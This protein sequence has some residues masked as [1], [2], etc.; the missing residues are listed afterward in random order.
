MTLEYKLSVLDK[1]EEQFEGHRE[2]LKKSIIK[3]HNEI[4]GWID[5]M[6]DTKVLCEYYVLKRR[7]VD[8]MRTYYDRKGRGRFKLISEPRAREEEIIFIGTEREIYELTKDLEVKDCFEEELTDRY[9]ELY[10][11]IDGAA[12]VNVIKLGRN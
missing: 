10:D 3:S 12:R 7:D 4:L 2:I 6:D 11:S 8:E 1:L 5:N 9:R